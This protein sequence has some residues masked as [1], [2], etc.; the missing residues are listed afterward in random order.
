M[1]PVL[2]YHRVCPDHEIGIDSRSLC[3]SP[4]QF[5]TQMRLIKIFGY[6]PVTIQNMVA[7]LQNRKN[8]PRHPIVITFDDGYED[9]YTYAYPIL[10][11]Y[12]FP[13]AVFLVTDYI[14]K[15]NNWDSGNLSLLNE[16]QIEEMHLGG[17]TFGSHTASHID[18]VQSDLAKI[19]DELEISRKKIEFL[20]SSSDISFCYP[21]TRYN[22]QARQ[23]VQDLGYSCAFAGDQGQSQQHTDLF[24]ILRIQ[25]FP[26][27]SLFGFWK[28]IQLWY[29]EWMSMQKRL[30]QSK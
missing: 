10:K 21:Y 16:A 26:S 7:F 2:C 14:G 3:V 15:K 20:T 25:V 11:R 9:N 17:I 23:L 6:T 4:E 29:P 19:K 24:D 13:A 12:S 28:K 1:I 22:E 18:M 27:T 5:A 8:P 30:K